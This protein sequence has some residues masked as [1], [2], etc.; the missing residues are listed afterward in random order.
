MK[1]LFTYLMSGAMILIL[2]TS[3]DWIIQTT[4][5]TGNL[6][7]VIGSVIIIITLS[8]ALGF[9]SEKVINQVKNSFKI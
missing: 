3:F 7:G 4:K 9:S 8:V 5:A 2:A 6:A 1:N